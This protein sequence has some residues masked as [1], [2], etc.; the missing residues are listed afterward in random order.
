MI[1]I[2]KL[3]SVQ[4]N[5]AE[6]ADKCVIWL[7][8]LGADGNDFAPI[9][10]E[11]HLPSRYKVRFVLPHAPVMPVTINQG[12][13]MR[14]W[15]DIYHADI[16]AKI[17]NPGI[18]QSVASINTLIEHEEAQGISA[19]NIILAGFSQG[20]VIA[21]ITGLLYPKPLA[22]IIALSGL[23]PHAETVVKQ[24]SVSNRNIPIFIGHGSQDQIV[25]ERLGRAAYE[26]LLQ[27][28]YPAEWHGYHMAHS[29]C[30][31]EI[32][33]ISHWIQKIWK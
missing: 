16:S 23:L 28:A 17:D 3:S 14:A 24:G 1:N 20:A 25:P 30:T 8:G 19:D 6:K 5:P 21:L 27:A 12:Y 9:V 13:E 2:E 10:P 22:G 15:F 26:V 31:E 7:H 29:V 18:E 4:I 11:L 33:D 32:H